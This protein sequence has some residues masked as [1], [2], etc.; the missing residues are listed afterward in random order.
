MARHLPIT[1]LCAA[2]AFAEGEGAPEWI[3]LLPA[4]EIRTVDGRGPYTVKSMPVLVGRLNSALTEGRRMPID[5]CHAT[6]KGKAIGAPAPAR[7]WFTKF[8]ARDGGLWAQVDWNKSGTQLMDDR[9]YA[10]ISPVILHS[11]DGEVLDVLRASL[12]NTPNIRGLVALHSEETGMDWKAKLCA[13]L[14]LDSGADDAAVEAALTAQHD[15]A[16]VA[17]HATA[18]DSPAVV[19]LQSQLAEVTGELNTIR[20]DRRR[21]AATVF[22]DAAIAAGRVGVKPLRDH[23][24]ALHM[25]NAERAQAMISG[26]PIL[27]GE[28]PAAGQGPA[29]DPKGLDATDRQVIALMGISEE[30]YLAGLKG[31]GVRKEA[32]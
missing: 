15:A 8:E 10:G 13:L 25:E 20:E 7:G 27:T 19:A 11:V 1:A 21:E 30:D 26:Q 32:L 16:R 17:A 12:T 5:E 4:G 23:Y 22:V 31:S 14:G 9:S 29:A 3:N 24:I 28:T 2:T 6:D 18:L